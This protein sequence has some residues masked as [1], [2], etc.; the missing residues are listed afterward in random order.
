M[1]EWLSN[2]VKSDVVFLLDFQASRSVAGAYERT[3]LAQRQCRKNEREAIATIVRCM[4]DV[5]VLAAISDA[6]GHKNQAAFKHALSE[7]F[8]RELD[9]DMSAQLENSYHHLLHGVSGAFVSGCKRGRLRPAR[10]RQPVDESTSA[11]EGERYDLSQQRTNDVIMQAVDDAAASDP[12]AVL[13][14]GGGSAGLSGG[15]PAESVQ[16]A[17]GVVG[18]S[19]S[20]PDPMCESAGCDVAELRR[21][22]ELESVRLWKGMECAQTE[23][24]RLE[25]EMRNLRGA[26]G[27][28]AVQSASLGSLRTRLAALSEQEDQPEPC[29]FRTTFGFQDPMYLWRHEACA[30][31]E[32]ENTVVEGNAD[33]AL[34][35]VERQD[36]EEEE[37]TELQ[38]SE[39][40]SIS[41]AIR[42]SEREAATLPDDGGSCSG[43]AGACACIR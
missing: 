29:R 32:V 19:P 26:P 27:D 22:F 18:A 21:M 23:R 31:H 15:P 11:V 24:R 38:V 5:V 1:Q 2:A 42:R 3:L 33:G 13:P 6:G 39:S 37:S 41:E 9:K 4:R 34:A 17:G 36:A 20:T 8:G 16:R 25:M 30:E 12:E 7:C 28:G 10:V 14:R 43:G 40:E 35:E